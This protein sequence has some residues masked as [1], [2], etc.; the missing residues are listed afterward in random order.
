MSG[1]HT[2]GWSTPLLLG[3]RQPHLLGEMLGTGYDEFV[4]PFGIRGLAREDGQALHLLALASDEPGQ[5]AFREL[6]RHAKVAYVAIYVWEIWNEWLP[7]VLE[8]YGF[9][10]MKA[11]ALTGEMLAGMVW[12]KMSELP[13]PPG[14]IGAGE[15][16]S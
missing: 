9:E 10:P 7:A 2:L 15:E 6:I 16:Q 14:T 1:I 8:R 5:G 3:Q 4:S 12:H 11:P 13:W